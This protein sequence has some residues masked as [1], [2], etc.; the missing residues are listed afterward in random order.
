MNAIGANDNVCC[1]SVPDFTTESTEITE[2]DRNHGNPGR[3][4]IPSR[5]GAPTAEPA[6]S[7]RAEGRVRIRMCNPL[8]PASVP[9]V[10]SVVKFRTAEGVR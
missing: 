7:P 3:V 1:R 9:S 4:P 10:P 5:D 6:G 2:T 8:L